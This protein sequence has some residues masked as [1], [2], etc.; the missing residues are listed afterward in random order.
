MAGKNKVGKALKEKLSTLKIGETVKVA[1]IFEEPFYRS[2]DREEVISTLEKHLEEKVKKLLGVRADNAR[3]YW[4]LPGFIA[5]LDGDTIQKLLE[6][7]EVRSIDLAEQR[8]KIPVTRRK[9]YHPARAPF[10]ESLWQYKPVNAAALWD[11]GLFGEG[12]VV[13]HLDT[14]INPW[15]PNLLG[16]I[17]GWAK[18]EQDGKVTPGKPG[19]AFDDNGHGTFT[20]GLIVAGTKDNPLGIAPA[21]KLFSVKVL[22]RDG[23]GSLEQIIAGLQFIALQKNISIVNMSWGVEGF[24]SLLVQPMVNLLLLGILPVAA[25]GN[26]GPE[27]SSSPGNIPGVLGIGALDFYPKTANYK[28]LY[29]A[30]FSNTEFVTPRTATFRFPYYL[31]PDLLAPG[32]NVVSTWSKGYASQNGSSAAAPI[33]SGMLA[34][35]LEKYKLAPETLFSLLKISG[36]FAG[37]PNF[38]YGW[39]IPDAG[40]LLKYLAEASYLKIISQNPQKKPFEGMI[41]YNVRGQ[42]FIDVGYL[43]PVTGRLTLPVPANTAVKLTVSQ[44]QGKVKTVELTTPASTTTK[45]VV[46]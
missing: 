4:L 33:I 6:N 30:P 46:V 2:L 28:F 40:K 43:H 24:L 25:I 42:D 18:V 37:N 14:G 1:V 32:V 22:D 26:D 7:P 21:A 23:S 20:G 13:G 35:I 12:I 36:S 17:V 41:S 19:E 10:K 38:G 3:S 34:A 31:K 27:T 39:G 44:P 45:E 8:V 29:P 11:K 15:H 16:K 5:E 9:I